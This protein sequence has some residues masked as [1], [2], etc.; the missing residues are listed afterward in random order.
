MFA[1]GDNVLIK[2]G[3]SLYG[4]P[5][6]GESII[7]YSKEQVVLTVTKSY[8]INGLIEELYDVKDE[9]G[10][11]Y[12]GCRSSAFVHVSS[13]ILTKKELERINKLNNVRE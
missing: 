1:V 13:S 2:E 4:Q 5:P 12:C 3:A 9:F 10:V 7:R 8:R 6:V 11:A